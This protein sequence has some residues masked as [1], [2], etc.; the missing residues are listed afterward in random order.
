MRRFA[1]LALAVGLASPVLA[2]EP[3]PK[4]VP[5][6]PL[7]APGEQPAPEQVPKTKAA[8]P[9]IY[10]V[11][12]DARKDIAAALAKARR[13]NQRVL[14]QWGGNWCGWCHLLHETFAKDRA[15]AHELNYEYQVVLVDIGHFDKQ[16][17]L[18][19]QYG[20]ELKKS[21]VP[22][23]TVL[24][25]DGKVIANQETGALEKKASEGEPA[26]TPGHDPAKVLAF[27]KQQEA[28]HLQ[29]DAVLAEARE[30]AKASGKRVLVRWGAPWCPWCHRLDD[31]LA[32]P[33]VASLIAKDYVSVKIDQDRMAG[34]KELLAKERGGDTGGIPWFAIE[35]AK[36]TVLATSDLDGQNVG[37]PSEPKEIEHFLSILKK[38]GKNLGADDL[39]AIRKT[40][41]EEKAKTDAKSGA[42]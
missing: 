28:T 7:A 26:P 40:L 10:D 5:M 33:E 23:L 6:T 29:A 13:E 32:R 2:Q 24:G 36:G 4:T 42:H 19:D 8:K 9:P 15:I 31:W 12:A 17:D 41:D 22:Y 20:A 21:G 34:G 35:D 18:A 37:F 11:S 1:V 3:A 39:A 27:L 30:S 16:M 14:I 38:T 25:A